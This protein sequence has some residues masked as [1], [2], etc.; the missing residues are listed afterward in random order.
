VDL[1][2][3][4]IAVFDE[5]AGDALDVLGYDRSGLRRS[6]GARAEAATLDARITLRRA[7]RRYAE[8]ASRAAQSLYRRARA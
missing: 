6:W 1:D 2:P 4:E 3:Y 8:R 5:V 7:R